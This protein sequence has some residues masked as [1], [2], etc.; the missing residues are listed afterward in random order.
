M[1][2]IQEQFAAHVARARA[3]SPFA[4]T[5]AKPLIYL[6][7]STRKTLTGCLV[8]HRSSGAPLEETGLKPGHTLELRVPKTL[9][10]TKPDHQL[11]AFEY[12]SRSYTFDPV[13]GEETHLPDWIIRAFSPLK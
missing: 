13:T 8:R 5:S 6:K 3:A 12:D 4:N 10:P 11:D 9:L 2:S 7:G 1:P